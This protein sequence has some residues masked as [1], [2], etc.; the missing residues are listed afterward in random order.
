M[1]CR[2]SKRWNESSG[3]GAFH[4]L[5]RFLR[6]LLHTRTRAHTQAQPHVCTRSA[7]CLCLCVC[8]HPTLSVTVCAILPCTLLFGPALVARH[9]SAAFFVVADIALRL[10]RL[11]LPHSEA[12]VHVLHL[13]SPY[14]HRHIEPLIVS[15]P[16]SPP[17]S[18]SSARGMQTDKRL[19]FGF[20]VCLRL[21][22]L[23]LL[24]R[25]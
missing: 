13:P 24:I 7:D 25:F 17:F 22:G 9:P 12:C 10:P 3:K 4:V 14:R 18:Y 2:N 21:C 1:S 20:R 19:R 6:S 23:R 16:A 8:F 15:S 5:F 11:P